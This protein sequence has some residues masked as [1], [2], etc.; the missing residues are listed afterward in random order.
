MNDNYIKAATD[1]ISD[2]MVLVNIASRRARE[3]ARGSKPMVKTEQGE[4]YLDIALHEIA[5][6]K[7]VV[8]ASSQIDK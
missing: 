3:L 8:D 7:I 5:E 4:N 2:N 6:K 1:I